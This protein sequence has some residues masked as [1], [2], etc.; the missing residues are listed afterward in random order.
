MARSLHVAAALA[1]AALSGGAGRAATEPGVASYDNSAVVLAAKPSPPPAP[2]APSQGLVSPAVS[3]EIAS[4][5]PSYK[6]ADG[7]PEV[8]APD[9]VANDA[10]KPRNLIPRLPMEMLGKYE[11]RES[12]IPVFRTRDLYTEEGLTEL[13]FKEHPGLRIGNLFNLNAAAA[14]E[15]IVREQLF[16]ARLDLVDSAFAMATGGDTHEIEA[17]RQDITEDGFNKESPVGR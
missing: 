12:R 14:H 16:A 10:E 9:T 4:G 11:V 5:I 6:A 13:S 15:R 17:M 8:A 3:A 2:A 7:A 1:F